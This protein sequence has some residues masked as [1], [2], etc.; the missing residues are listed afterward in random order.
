MKLVF[1]LYNP[2]DNSPDSQYYLFKLIKVALM[3]DMYLQGGI[4]TVLP[5]HYIDR[6]VHDSLYR[7]VC[8]TNADSLQDQLHLVALYDAFITT[9]KTWGGDADMYML[10]VL[11]NVTICLWRI[12]LCLQEAGTRT[13]KDQNP[14]PK[15]VFSHY[16]FNKV[17]RPNAPFVQP[18]THK[19]IHLLSTR[20]KGPKFDSETSVIHPCDHF[21]TKASKSEQVY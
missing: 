5:N 1:R 12:A 9:D 17:D 8:N 10:L 6:Y 16:M 15:Y 3:Y 11:F 7:L 14:K 2:D 18:I 4:E 21:N 19:T 20:F 13:K